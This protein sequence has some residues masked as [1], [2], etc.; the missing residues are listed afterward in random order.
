MDFFD[1]EHEGDT[2]QGRDNGM[3]SYQSG[4][5]LLPL[6]QDGRANDG[7]GSEPSEELEAASAADGENNVTSSAGGG[8]HEVCSGTPCGA[9]DV[10]GGTGRENALVGA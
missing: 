1:G 2:E 10:T 7:L 4:V 8:D 9:H 5:P 6:M 3:V